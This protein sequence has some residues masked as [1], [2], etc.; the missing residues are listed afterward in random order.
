M[1]CV[2][3]MIYSGI[4]CELELVEWFVILKAFLL[5]ET[6]LWEVCR[7]RVVHVGLINFEVYGWVFAEID[8]NNWPSSSVGGLEQ[9]V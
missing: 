2:D 9:L 1:C 7:L 5:W 6:D 3:D 8:S 4:V